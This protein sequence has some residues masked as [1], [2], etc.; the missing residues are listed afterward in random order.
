M[1]FAGPHRRARKVPI[2]AD[3]EVAAIAVRVTGANQ[4]DQHVLGVNLGRD[5]PG[6]KL[7]DLRPRRRATAARAAQTGTYR[8]HRGIEVG[9]VFYLGTQVLRADEGATYLDVDGEEK[10][11]EMGCYGIGVTRICAAAIEQHHDE[12]GIIWPM[13]LAPFHVEILHCRQG[14][15]SWPRRPRSSTR[16]LEARGI[17]VLYDDRDERPGVKFKDADLLGIPLR[18]T[19]GKRGLAERKIEVKRRGDKDAELVGLDEVVAARRAQRAR[20]AREQGM[21]VDARQ[22]VF[23]ALDVASLPEAIALADLLGEDAPRVKVGLELFAAAGPEAVRAFAGRGREVFLDL[24]LHDIPETV[25]ARRRGWPRPTARASSRCTPRAGGRCSK[26]RCAARRTPRCGS[27]RSPCS[28]ASSERI[29]RPMV[30]RSIP[31]RWCVRRA[32]L[33]VDGRLQGDDRFAA[34]GGGDPCARSDPNRSCHHPGRAPERSGRRATRS[35]STRR[36]RPSPPAR[37]RS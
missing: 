14:A 16:E 33:A 4:A 12:D 2:F 25:R 8:A 28:P 3:L 32:R 10:P 15:P 11:M 1:G 13:A 23:V 18:V 20:R 19:V 7:A 9:H 31:R 17:E 26:R 22:R 30:T 29:C 6:A 21:S 36:A 24:K 37:A 27:S 34:R 5:C 35:A